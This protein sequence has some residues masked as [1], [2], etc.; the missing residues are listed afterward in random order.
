MN[1]K[2]NARKK[3]QY[4][5]RKKVSGTARKPRLNVFR[6]NKDI[7]AQLIDDETSQTLASASSRDNDISAQK[8]TKV[9]SS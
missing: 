3:I 8:V 9:E 4:R 5:I 7:Y 2:I 1:S 6:S